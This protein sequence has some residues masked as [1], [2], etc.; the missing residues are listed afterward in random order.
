MRDPKRIPKVVEVLQ[1][2]W[3]KHPDQRLGQLIVNAASMIVG[4]EPMPPT[5]LFHIEDDALLDGLARFNES[6]PSVPQL[7]AWPSPDSFKA[8]QEHAE[9]IR[10][11]RADAD[12][13][14]EGSRDQ[15]DSS[16]GP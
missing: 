8:S 2:L 6:P 15:E 9:R 16:A 13:E 12:A 1:K 10:K 5:P 11:E 3:E 4:R 7:E 14:A